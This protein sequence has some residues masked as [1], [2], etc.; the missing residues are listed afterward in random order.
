MGLVARELIT[1]QEHGAMAFGPKA[2]TYATTSRPYDRE[3]AS[4]RL[5]P[6]ALVEVIK[7]QNGPIKLTVPTMTLC[8]RVNE[9]QGIS[10][11]SGFYRACRYCLLVLT[12]VL[13]S[14]VPIRTLVLTTLQVCAIFLTVLQLKKGA[15]L[16]RGWGAIPSS[17]RL[18]AGFLWGRPTRFP[19]GECK[20]SA[21]TQGAVLTF[22]HPTVNGLIFKE[23]MA[24]PEGVEPTTF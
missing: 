6:A 24:R 22:S 7:P 8:W 10:D 1:A 14:P 9:Q 3:A 12:T 13:T 11:E 16:G 18:P 15:A 23:N 20:L 21:K 2:W 4:L 5:I 19:V 17:P